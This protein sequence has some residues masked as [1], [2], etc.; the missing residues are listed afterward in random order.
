MDGCADW[1]F[2]EPRDFRFLPIQAKHF[3]SSD[4]LR[5][6]RGLRGFWDLLAGPGPR[7]PVGAVAM[8]SNSKRSCFRTRVHWGK[9]C[10][11][12]EGNFFQLNDH[13]S[14]VSKIGHLQMRLLVT[15]KRLSTVRASAKAADQMEI[16]QNSIQKHEG[17]PLEK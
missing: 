15:L 17:E 13:N 5:T 4:P 10:I 2:Q 12:G 9:N 11:Q 16:N 6:D 1:V 7:R 8:E 14:S 3:K